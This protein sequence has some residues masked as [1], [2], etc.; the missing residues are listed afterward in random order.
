MIDTLKKLQASKLYLRAHPEAFPLFKEKFI[1]KL[2]E[3][4]SSYNEGEQASF[5]AIWRI[6]DLFSGSLIVPPR[7]WLPKP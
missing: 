5:R 4:Y 3:A 1:P 2:E 7:V 6:A